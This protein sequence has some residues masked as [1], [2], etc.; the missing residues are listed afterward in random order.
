MKYV[1][2]QWDNAHVDGQYVIFPP[3][4]C[5]PKISFEGKRFSDFVFSS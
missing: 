2:I 1:H 5:L 4:I 3:Y